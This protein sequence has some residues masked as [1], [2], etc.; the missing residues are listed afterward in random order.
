MELP[1][2]VRRRVR[3]RVAEGAEREALW[4][5]LVAVYGS[6]H[7]YAGYTSRR[8]PVVVLEPV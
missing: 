7:D 5:R 1:G 4:P 8:I 3:P 6:Y 2:G